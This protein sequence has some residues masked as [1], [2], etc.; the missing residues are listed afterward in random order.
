V[1]ESFLLVADQNRGVDGNRILR[2]QAE[3]LGALGG[4]VDAR[5][6]RYLGT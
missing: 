3:H 4:R 5:R 1:I 2:S 6:P